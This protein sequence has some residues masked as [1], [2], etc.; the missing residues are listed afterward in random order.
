MLG[1]AAPGEVLRS[2][3]GIH[4]AIDGPIKRFAQ[5]CAPARRLPEAGNEKPALPANPVYRILNVGKIKDRDTKNAERAVVEA[6]FV[7]QLH[8]GFFH[9]K[10]PLGTGKLTRGYSAIVNNN[11]VGSA[12]LHQ[13]SLEIE[14]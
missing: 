10:N 5:D 3:G 9:R 8:I 14:R 6:S 1:P 7:S 2:Q 11:P 13:F 12:S 4:A